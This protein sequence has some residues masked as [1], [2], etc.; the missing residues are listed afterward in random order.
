MSK[1]ILALYDDLEQA[2]DAVHALDGAGFERERI[3][4][5]IQDADEKY[6][7]YGEEPA[8]VEEVVDGMVAGGLLGGLTGLVVG[9]FTL[10]IP[11]VGP[12]LA[13]GPL[14][15]ALAGAGA[16]AVLGTLVGALVDMG[17]D[18]ETARYYAEGIH[19]GGVLVA[20]TTADARADEAAAILDD[21]YPVDLEARAAEWDLFEK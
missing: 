4:L 17:V 16:G 15:V 5:V 21:H 8:E 19:R 2:H 13:A 12:L 10:V 3:S 9:L 18:E 6:A 11:G 7:E 1:T 20:V 14:A